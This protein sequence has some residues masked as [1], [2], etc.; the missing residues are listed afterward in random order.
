MS[1]R[2]FTRLPEAKFYTEQDYSGCNALMGIGFSDDNENRRLIADQPLVTDTVC[3][4][5]GIDV[6]GV[7]LHPRMTSVAIPPSVHTIRRNAFSVLRGHT[8]YEGYYSPEFDDPIGN[9]HHKRLRTVIFSDGLREIGDRAFAAMSAIVGMKLPKGLEYIGEEAFLECEG[10]T[11]I[12]IPASVRTVKK[13]VF[14]SCIGIKKVIFYDGIEELPSNLFYKNTALKELTLPKTATKL[15]N[16]CFSGCQALPTVD[17]PESVTELGN[18]V[19][20]G[21]ASL[22][23]FTF[24]RDVTSGKDVF[25]GCE[26]LSRFNIEAGVKHPELLPYNPYLQRI[27]ATK[28]HPDFVTVDG[29]VYTKDKKT[30][31]RVPHGISGGFTVPRGVTAIGNRAFAECR[32]ITEIS[33]PSTVEIVGEEAFCDCE[34]IETFTLGG[35]VRSVGNRAFAKCKSLRSLHVSQSVTKISVGILSECGEV[36][37]TVSPGNPVYKIENGVI[38]KK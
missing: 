3:I 38:V 26:K 9:G 24:K 32:G 13:G 21:C 23:E 8:T 30:L 34:N 36:E 1:K 17:L 6:I 15:G 14:D 37:I 4:P 2:D 35:K 7:A 5:D 11:E 33:L 22:T 29:A 10:L 19:F 12:I 27:E 20:F 25:S 18:G 31:V 28:S 16:Y